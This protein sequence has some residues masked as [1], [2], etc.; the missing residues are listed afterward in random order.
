[1]NRITVS[2]PPMLKI[3]LWLISGLCLVAVSTTI[4]FS[5]GYSKVNS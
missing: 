2:T 5:I 4:G 3:W 1:M